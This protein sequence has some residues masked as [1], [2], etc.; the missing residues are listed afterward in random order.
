MKDTVHVKGLR[1]LEKKL[2]KLGQQNA[3]KALRQ[4]AM[5]ATTPGLKAAKR[6]APIG[7]Q[8]HRTYK[9]RLVAPGFL[10]RS[11][12]RRSSYRNG[13]ARV[14]VGVR[15]E[16]FYGVLFVE[17]GTKPHRIPKRE[18]VY[19]HFLPRRNGPGVY[20]TKKSKLRGGMAKKGS[21]DQWAVCWICQ[22]PWVQGQ[23]LVGAGL[24]A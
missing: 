24:G 18:K 11:I 19:R 16:A 15:K 22:S 7:K 9:G 5:N 2:A 10:R 1:E 17:E 20:V 3:G 12:V 13:W 14:I 23:S 21:E 6:E 4:A 8:M